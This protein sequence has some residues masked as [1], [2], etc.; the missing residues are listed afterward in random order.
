MKMPSILNW[1]NTG[2]LCSKQLE[3]HLQRNADFLCPYVARVK[4]C[5][6][7]MQRDFK[8]L[9]VKESIKLALIFSR[10]ILILALKD[11]G[12]ISL[13]LVFQGLVSSGLGILYL[14]FIVG[15]VAAIGKFTSTVL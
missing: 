1:K 12:K 8:L 13:L 14:I 9:V 2:Q 11:E 10:V 7:F 4:I 15:T 6:F 3:N 5:F